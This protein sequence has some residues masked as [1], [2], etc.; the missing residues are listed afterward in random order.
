[1]V[2][3]SQWSGGRVTGLNWSCRR[4]PGC[5][6]LR[7]IKAP[8]VIQPVAHD[9][10][11]QAIYDWQSARDHRGANRSVAVAPPAPLAGL[12]GLF[13]KIRARG[14][15][16]EFDA[17][18]APANDGA[19]GYFDSLVEH[20]FVVIEDRVL[21][22]A[23]AQIDHLLLG[24]SGIY[25]VDRKAWVGQ[26]LVTSDAVFVDGRQRMGAT[27]D[28]TRAAAAFG[29]AL[30]YELK[31]LGVQVM[32]G[33]LFERAANRTFEGHLGKVLVGGVRGLPRL[34]RGRGEPVLGPE[35]IVRLAVAADRL[36]D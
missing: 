22:H 17:F 28:V 32:A 9:G 10:S 5:E 19:V 3:R 35:T 18:D 15:E 12:R 29:D 6:G 36:L 25:V 34:I 31:P 4:A 26:V 27:D 21:P 1:M 2:V 7:R 24:P 8:D 16:P 20:G 11:A 30:D 13:G 33:V 14:A 23:R